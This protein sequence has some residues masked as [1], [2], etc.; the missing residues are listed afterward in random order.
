MQ[1][2]IYEY[3]KAHLS[4]NNA[5][6]Y[7]MFAHIFSEEKNAINELNK[8]EQESLQIMYMR[9]MQIIY[10]ENWLKEHF[11]E[12]DCIR[13]ITDSDYCGAMFGFQKFNN[14]TGKNIL[15][16]SAISGADGFGTK[17]YNSKEMVKEYYRL[18][19]EGDAEVQ[20]ELGRQ[21]TPGIAYGA[22]KRNASEAAKY[23]EMAAKQGM[24]DAMFNLANLYINGDINFDINLEKGFFWR[25]KCADA[26]DIEACY[27]LGKMYYEGKG[28]EVDEQKGKEYIKKAAD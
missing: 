24:I 26:G 6:N 2:N 4:Y 17:W 1:N 20:Y 8:E 27:M 3:A 12:L 11:L 25:K 19:E 28:T 5:E 16:Q 14:V 10:L 13:Y 18:A 9:C 21:L 23:Y 22:F 7:Q 15:E